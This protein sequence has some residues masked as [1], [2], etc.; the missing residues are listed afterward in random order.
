MLISGKDMVHSSGMAGLASKVTN[1]GKKTGKLDV[2]CIIII[3][4]F[5]VKAVSD[6]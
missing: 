3:E 5:R 1:R 6:M 2:Y 4:E